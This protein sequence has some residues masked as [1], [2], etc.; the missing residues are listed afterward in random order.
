MG[1]L[2]AKYDELG[3]EWTKC[4]TYPSML[5]YLDDHKKLQE[6]VHIKRKIK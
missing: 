3:H 4:V 2:S 1:M 5:N 6:N